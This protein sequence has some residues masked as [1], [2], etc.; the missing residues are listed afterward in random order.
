ML[1]RMPHVEKI[2]SNVEEAL[3][4]NKFHNMPMEK[5]MHYY[6]RLTSYH[7]GCLEAVRKVL[8]YF[9]NVASSEELRLL[10]MY[11]TLDTG[12]KRKKFME[13]AGN[14]KA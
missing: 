11:R 6:D 14:F 1:E 12:E 10:N 8:V 13:H 2:I 7:L 5:K 3:A 9:P 4:R